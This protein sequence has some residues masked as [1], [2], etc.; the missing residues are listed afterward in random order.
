LERVVIADKKIIGARQNIMKAN[1]NVIDGIDSG[2][3][4]C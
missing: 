1:E 3:R 2:G 4:L